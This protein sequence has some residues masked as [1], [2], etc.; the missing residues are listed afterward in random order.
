MQTVK[1]VPVLRRQ[2]IVL[3]LFVMLW[4]CQEFGVLADFDEDGSLDSDDCHPSDSQIYPGAVDSDGDGI[5]QNCDDV[6]GNASDQDGDGY[7]LETDCDDEDPEAYPGAPGWSEDCER[8]EDTGSD[9][10]TSDTHQDTSGDTSGID[11]GLGG[12]K[13][14]VGGGCACSNRPTPPFET[15]WFVAA[16]GVV[17]RRR[18]KR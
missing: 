18:R 3:L 7:P 12:A 9:T 2:T 5:D 8:L 6:D 11:T 10:G 1:L 14:T 17:I 15:W 16:L 4:S 13:I